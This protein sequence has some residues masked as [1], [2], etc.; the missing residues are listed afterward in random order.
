MFIEVLCEGGADVPAV[1]DILCRRFDLRRDEHFRVHPHHGK[2]KLPPNPMARP[3][4][5]RRGLLDQLPAKL[6]GYGR[7]ESADYAILVVVLVD[8]DDDDCRELKSS[9]LKMYASLPHKPQRVLFR[10]AVEETESWL[11][12]DAAAVRAAFPHANL[13]ALRRIQPDAVCGAWEALAGALGMNAGQ[14]TGQDK[15]HWAEAIT[16]HL[17]LKRPRSPSLRAFVTGLE[18]LLGE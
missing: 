2:G 11:I 13:A 1:C 7:A 15:M 8:A 3:E 12:A 4:P 18:A 9:L 5:R 6:R 10:V 16:P 14:C 17:D